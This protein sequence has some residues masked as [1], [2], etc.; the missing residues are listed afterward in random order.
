MNN[1]NDSWQSNDNNSW[2]SSP[3]PSP[4]ETQQPETNSW[5]TQPQETPSWEQNQTDNSWLHSNSNDLDTSSDSLSYRDEPSISHASDSSDSH[6]YDPDKS[7]FQNVNNLNG[8][9]SG[10]NTMDEGVPIN[11][12][13][14]SVQ[15][16]ATHHNDEAL[17]SLAFFRNV[18]NNKSSSMTG[19]TGA[20]LAAAAL[21]ATAASNANKT[22]NSNNTT[23]TNNHVGTGES[24]VHLNNNNRLGKSKML[25]TN[26]DA[27]RELF[28]SHDAPA[29]DEKNNLP[30]IKVVKHPFLKTKKRLLN[31]V[32]VTA[33]AIGALVA[34]HN[35][36][37]PSLDTS[38]MNQDQIVAAMAQENKLSAGIGDFEL[39]VYKA[40]RLYDNNVPKYFNDTFGRAFYPE[41]LTFLSHK[42]MQAVNQASL[43]K[44]LKDFPAYPEANTRFLVEDPSNKDVRVNIMTNLINNGHFS[45]Y[46]SGLLT[47]LE[48]TM[49]TDGIMKFKGQPVN[50][51]SSY[52]FKY[53]DAGVVG[54]KIASD[55]GNNFTAS[56]RV[57]DL[58]SPEYET[59]KSL[60]SVGDLVSIPVSNAYNYITSPMIKFAGLFSPEDSMKAYT[61]DPKLTSTEG[62]IAATN[63]VSKKLPDLYY[64]SF[65][66]DDNQKIKELSAKSMSEPDGGKSFQEIIEISARNHAN[67][68]AEELKA[69]GLPQV[70]KIQADKA[71]AAQKAAA[72]RKE[73]LNKI[74][75]VVQPNPA[76]AEADK[77]KGIEIIN[78]LKRPKL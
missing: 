56:G 59:I 49:F 5:E 72:D 71:A 43:N 4:W 20:T 39:G 74:K 10:L 50:Q 48:D 18:H 69:S 35:I 75:S 73:V 42:K 58:V 63:Q 27:L 9:K 21:A 24:P 16:S 1:D 17:E 12:H 31:F 64:N 44:M 32:K 37:T 30:E 57:S 15:H 46:Q 70:Q 40:M 2:S 28:K 19:A 26:D 34:V 13:E 65:S 38:N 14:S 60:V 54:T 6:S 3:A 33:L 78:E 51:T 22:I 77:A 29:Q 25:P 68:L 55:A 67:I 23:D 7:K 45:K 61:K 47:H 53:A 62:F 52:P 8:L 36:T 41:G 66:K 76:T 11:S